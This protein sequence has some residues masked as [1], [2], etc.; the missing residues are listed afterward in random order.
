MPQSAFIT[1]KA[2]TC[3]L[4]DSL[5]AIVDAVRHKRIRLEHIPFAMARLPYS[6]P[7][8]LINGSESDKLENRSADYFYGTLFAVVSR[9]LGDAGMNEAEIADL[10]VFL[11]STSM[12]VPVFEGNHRCV[13]TV[14]GMFLESSSGYG[15]LAGAILARFGMGGN[16]YTFTTACTS[17]A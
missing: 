15:K 2:M 4:G 6:R 14:S 12:D 9:A 3:S 11:G 10:H 5:E 17:S 8:Y 7:Y 13:S 1:G 16:C